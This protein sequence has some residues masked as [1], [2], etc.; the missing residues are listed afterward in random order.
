MAL[1][2]CCVVFYGSADCMD[3]QHALLSTINRTI[4]D[5]FQK[6]INNESVNEPRAGFCKSASGC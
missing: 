4:K 1:A 5:Q 3:G 6:Q 2:V